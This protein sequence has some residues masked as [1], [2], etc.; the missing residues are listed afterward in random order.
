[1]PHS[2]IPFLNNKALVALARQSL[3]QPPCAA[4]ARRNCAAWESM[5]AG[6]DATRLRVAGTLRRDA[7]EE[8]TFA[9]HHPRATHG[10]FANAPIAPP[11]F[12]TTVAS[13]GSARFANMLSCAIPNT[14]AT[15]WTRVSARRTL[16]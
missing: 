3:S 6:F 13:S 5:H 2:S 1:M 9:E 7:D 8:P 15:T 14:A 4:C 10:S 12:H 16:H 11:P